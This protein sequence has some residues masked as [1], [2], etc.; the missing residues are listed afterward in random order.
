MP[1]GNVIGMATTAIG[2]L[3]S[4][5]AGC[6]PVTEFFG[7]DSGTNDYIFLS[8]TANGAAGAGC[9]GACLYNFVVS[10]DGVTESTPSAAAAGIAA[11]GGTSG[12]IID[13]NL[14]VANGESQIYYTTLSTQ[15]CG[16][17]GTATTGNCAV[18]VSPVTLTATT[19]SLA[20]GYVANG[21]SYQL[22]ASGG[23]LPLSWTLTSGT[24]PAGL[25]LS[26]GGLISGTPTGV[27]SAT[28]LVF[29]VH[30]SRSNVSSTGTLDL[31][32]AA[33]V[34]S[35]VA[36]PCATTGTQYVAYGGCTLV[37][38]GGT[39]PYTYS[40]DTSLSPGYAPIPPGLALN[41][42]TG[43]ISGTDYG[44]G[45]YTTHFMATDGV[46]TIVTVDVP[47]SLAGH[48]VTSFP[49]FPTDSV[50]HLKVTSLPVDTSWVAQ[51]NA[52]GNATIKPF[53]GALPN[54]YQPNGIPFLV[55]PYNQATL[56]VT[57]NQYTAF[58]GTTS[59]GDPGSLYRSV[60]GMTAPIPPYAPIVRGMRVRVLLA[61]GDDHVLVVQEAGGVNPASLWEMWLGVYTG[62]ASPLWTDGGNA[63]WTNIG[64]TGPGAYAMIPQ[65]VG[66]SDAAG[67]PI[68]PLLL[69]ADEVIGTGTPAA[70]NGVVQHPVR[71]TLDSTLGYYV[72]PATHQAGPGFCAGGYEDNNAMLSQ[73][74][75][76]TSCTQD[77]PSLIPMG[78]IYRLK[79]SAPT[80]ACAATSPQA[81]VIIQGLRDY[82]MILADNGASA[83]LIGTPDSR[84]NDADL[85]CLTSL[86]FSQFEPVLVQPQAADLSLVVGGVGNIVTSCPPGQT[87][88]NLPV[89][90]YRTITTSG[91]VA[92][93]T[94]SPAAKAAGRRR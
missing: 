77:T 14:P 33:T 61:D 2:A 23:V 20:E 35:V 54:T 85:N 58:F 4:D 52:F 5:V 41:P 88:Y 10:L 50:F 28:P 65:G 86:I 31:T 68:A 11:A 73:L 38:T 26:A 89:T 34:F 43:A 27:V 13:N 47:F 84:W 16:N 60:S 53:F 51:I 22:S 66:S 82:G 46:G 56:P 40:Y 69:T 42:A 9:A 21:Y 79:A 93:V 70:P 63:L 12:I 37:A 94:P 15:S 44:Q 18:Q 75:P 64:S 59:G 7:S 74:D 17:N 76:P 6:S 71:F 36:S 48:N 83:A 55:V 80:P 24:L 32:V 19:T 90:T 78:E 62:G 67:L 39:P 29:R 87:C 30:D 57:T 25:H 91:Q 8:V 45:A 3:T 1:A 81:A 92:P 49:L 72:W